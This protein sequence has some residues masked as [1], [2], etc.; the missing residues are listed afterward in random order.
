MEK[1]AL[2]VHKRKTMH[3][4]GL[5]L[6]L[7]ILAACN[8]GGQGNLPTH[9]PDTAV[10]T[11]GSIPLPE[12]YTRICAAPGSYTAF[13]RRLP[14]KKDKTVYLFNG[15]KKGNQEAQYAVLDIDA[16]DRDL[17]QCADAVMRLRAEYLF[18]QKRPDEIKFRFHNGFTCDYSHYAA[19]YRLSFSGSRCSW[20]RQKPA[21]TSYATFRQYLDLVY[22]YAGT[23][24]LHRQLRP[25]A[26]ARIAPGAVLIQTRIPYGHAVTVMDMACS[27]STGDTIYLLSQSYMPAQDIHILNNPG[28]GKLSPWYSVRAAD[29]I[30][31]PEWTFSR[32]DLR[33]F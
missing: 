6:I 18:R 5:L 25:L 32:R 21:D 7:P 20:S 11:V 17:Q 3:M 4:S 9:R 16:G 13:L 23:R 8:Q 10:R 24:S 28:N 12:G 14:L 31:T 1:P 29:S 27:P 30:V 2:H 19:G 33:S 15:I 22:S 26:F